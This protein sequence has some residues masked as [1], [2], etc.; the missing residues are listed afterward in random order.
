MNKLK[1]VLIMAGGTGGHVFPALAVARALQQ[2]GISV[3]WLGTSKG[4]EARVVPEAG[5]PL[6]LI[7]ITGVRGKGLKSLLT[8]PWRIMI[9]I[10]QAMRIIRQFTPDIVLGFGGFVSGPGGVASWLLRHPLIIHEQNARAGTTNKLLARIASKVLEGFPDTFTMRDKI[11]TTGNPV[12]AE[13]AVLPPPMQRFANRVHPLRLLV[14]GGSLGAAAFNELVPKALA[15]L[16]VN[17]RPEVLHQ[18][19]DKHAGL[20]QQ[21]YTDLNVAATVQPFIA[22]MG[23]AYAWADVVLCRAGALT[24]AELCAAGLGAIL[25]PYP[26][27]TDDHQTANA[28]YLVKNAAAVL[29]Q[30]T[31]L[32]ALGLSEIIQELSASPDKR[33]QMAQAAYQLRKVDA[34]S[35]VLRICGEVCNELDI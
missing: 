23:G 25:V 20:T 18:A 1:K 19:G 10:M 24:I 5:I 21:H 33:A 29:I 14:I 27:A 9:A 12:R 4:L 26:H 34:T 15:L 13:I 7:T 6:H 31:D 3:A 16:P 28:N 11:V 32:T 17:E 30:Q 22:D 8:A 35:N 2:Q